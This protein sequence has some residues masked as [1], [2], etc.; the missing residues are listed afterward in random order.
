[1]RG[2]PLLV[3]KVDCLFRRP[4]LMI[5]K[6]AVPIRTLPAAP[7]FRKSRHK[8]GVLPPSCSKDKR[9]SA[10]KNIPSSVATQTSDVPPPVNTGP[11]YSRVALVVESAAWCSMSCRRLSLQS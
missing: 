5:R 9:L 6:P 7:T 10:A 4:W 2:F 1:M 3:N 8:Q 11:E